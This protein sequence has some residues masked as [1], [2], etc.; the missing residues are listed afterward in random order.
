MH[1][2]RIPEGDVLAQVVALEHHPSTVGGAFGGD[3]VGFRVD[4]RDA[5]P[6]AVADLIDL[7]A[8]QVAGPRRYGDAGI[9][10]PAHDEISGADGLVARGAH[11]S[12]PRP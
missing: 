12:G 1:G 11:P 5:P 7:P 9:V 3:T 10:V 4:R 8:A 6:V 2:G